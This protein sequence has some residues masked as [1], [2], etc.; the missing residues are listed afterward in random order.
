MTV[1]AR[2]T[3]LADR[4][5]IPFGTIGEDHYEPFQFGEFLIAQP[6]RGDQKNEA[7]RIFLKLWRGFKERQPQS[8]E[9]IRGVTQLLQLEQQRNFHKRSIYR[10][11]HSPIP[12][13]MPRNEPWQVV[14][15]LVPDQQFLALRIEDY[16]RIPQAVSFCESSFMRR[17]HEHDSPRSVVGDQSLIQFDTKPEFIG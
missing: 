1:L 13:P 8:P 2:F 6:D 12:G 10:F 3:A 15:I 11:F 7:G 14:C 16:F 9:R 17:P 4:R 5:R